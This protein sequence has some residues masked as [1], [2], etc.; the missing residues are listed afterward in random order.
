MLSLSALGAGSLE[1]DVAQ[2]ALAGPWEA[3][4]GIAMNQAPRGSPPLDSEERRTTPRYDLPLPVVVRAIPHQQSKPYHG[5]IRDISTGG[6]YFVADQEFAAGS[7]LEFTFALPV[8]ISKGI[9]VSIR[10][11]SR[12]LRTEE[13][14]EDDATRTGVAAIIE[15]IEFIRDEPTL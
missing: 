2:Q 14:R 10:G 9:A 11:H 12:V 8:E 13:R 6:I 5:K 3:R 4:V 15:K 1:P 7:Q